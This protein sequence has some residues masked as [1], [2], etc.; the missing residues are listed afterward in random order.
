[1]SVK[2]DIPEMASWIAKALN[3]SGYRADFT[4]ASARELDRFF[5]EQLAGPGDPKEGGFLAEQLG[6]RI[7]AVGSYVG[8]VIRR[9]SQGWTWADADDPED[10]INVR[11]Q[12]EA[13]VVW[14]VQRAMKRYAEGP[15]SGIAA[16]VSVLT[17][18]A[19]SEPAQPERRRRFFRSR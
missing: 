4:V 2:D 9:N 14:A 5:D 1:M 15:E 8:E 10:E 19:T 11:L 18:V 7:F 13:E 12:R 17:G 16:Y 6:P 3:A